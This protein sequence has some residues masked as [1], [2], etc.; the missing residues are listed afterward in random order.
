MATASNDDFIFTV[1][2]VFSDGNHNY[3]AVSI[4]DKNG[5]EIGGKCNTYDNF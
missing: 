3:F 5:Q 4:E 2:S 1:E